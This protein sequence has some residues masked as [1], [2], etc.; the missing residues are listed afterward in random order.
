[1]VKSGLLNLRREPVKQ[2]N[3]RPKQVYSLTG[4]GP[5]VEVG[6]KA[7]LFH[8]LN[9]TVPSKSSIKKETDLEGLAR[10]RMA[11]G[12]VYGSLEDSVVET[13]AKSKNTER[14]FQTLIFSAAMLSTK[15]VDQRYLMQR[16]KERGVE[17]PVEGILGEIDYLLNSPR[18]E[19]EDIRTLYEIRKRLAYH[20]PTSVRLKSR[21]FPLL[22]DEMIDVIGK[23]V[24]VK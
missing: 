11:Q 8:G 21:R 19:V 2:P 4:R 1:M 5:F 22:P 14:L 17:D 18:P 6:E 20:A 13:L 3:M 10:G 9:W 16:A 24:G 12:T 7:M 15:K 23:Q